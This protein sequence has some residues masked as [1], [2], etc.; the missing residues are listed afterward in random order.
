MAIILKN[1]ADAKTAGARREKLRR[2]QLSIVPQ[3]F[4]YC[5][6]ASKE[7][8]SPT[9]SLATDPTMSILSL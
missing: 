2:T 9:L 5:Y 1:R 6:Q 8:L 3:P 4:R 7:S